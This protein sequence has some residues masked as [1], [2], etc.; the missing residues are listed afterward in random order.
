VACTSADMPIPLS[1]VISMQ[2]QR[3]ERKPAKRA[4]RSRPKRKCAVFFLN[5]E[6]LQIFPDQIGI[7]T[8]ALNQFTIGAR[9]ADK[10]VFALISL[11][12]SNMP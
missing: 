10:F 11:P 5:F 3:H 1:P 8:A 4:F 12:Q 7:H 9:R 6:S 2:M